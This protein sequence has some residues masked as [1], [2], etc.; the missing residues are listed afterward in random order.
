MGVDDF[1]DMVDGLTR[2]FVVGADEDFSQQP[3]GDEL[4]ADDHEED[5]EQKKRAVGD[6]YFQDEPLVG[7]PQG[8]GEPQNSAGQPDQAENLKRAGRVT[9]EKLDCQHVQDDPRETEDAVL[10]FSM[11]ARPVMDLDLSDRNTHVAGDG[12]DEAMELAVELDALD[13]L[14]AE[15]FQGAPVIMELDSRQ[16][17]NQPVSDERREPARKEPVLSILAP[18]ADDVEAVLDLRQEKGDIPGAVLEVS[19]E[20]DDDLSFG[21]VE[22]SRKSGRLAEILSQPDELDPWLTFL[23]GL[24]DGPGVVCAAVI[25][26]DDF[27][28]DVEVLE[29]REEFFEEG[30]D[31]VLFVK[32]G[33]DDR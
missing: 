3:E 21:V 29:D 4:E 30:G 9:E 16:P 33:Y 10:G 24:K 23:Q 13:N 11:A 18:S 5:A 31:V 28:G 22:A 2:R 8:D 19:V 1:T 7:Q 27:E 6:A 14:S 32:N 25:D 15:G 20:A 26:N 17:G 12:R